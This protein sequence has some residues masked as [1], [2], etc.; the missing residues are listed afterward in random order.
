MNN[1]PAD[2][3]QQ[4]L[5]FHCSFKQM[6]MG[7]VSMIK[8]GSHSS[9]RILVPEFTVRA[10]TADGWTAARND[11]ITQ[12]QEMHAK[13]RAV[14]ADGTCYVSVRGIDLYENI[15]QDVVSIAI[16]GE[17]NS[18]VTL[19]SSAAQAEPIFTEGNK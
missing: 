12:I 7:T 13:L 10:R 6:E 16:V 8:A 1:T 15:V 3:T 19:D 14:K 9:G 18:M 2:L 17:D 5:G 4:D 11:I